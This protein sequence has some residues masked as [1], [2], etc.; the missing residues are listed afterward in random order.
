VS[1]SW[2]TPEHIMFPW[3][4]DPGAG[5]AGQSPPPEPPAPVPVVAAPPVPLATDAL[6][7][8]ADVAVLDAPVVSPEL[9]VGVVSRSSSPEST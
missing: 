5:T 9:L 4:Q 8:L 2:Q 7:E 1:P 6:L 3:V